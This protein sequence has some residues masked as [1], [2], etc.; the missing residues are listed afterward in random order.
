MNAIIYT[1]LTLLMLHGNII[2]VQAHN[3]TSMKACEEAEG[4]ILSITE[5]AEP[6]DIKSKCFAHNPDDSAK[7]DRP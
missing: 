6:Y 3:Y 5:G 4:R 1:G 2:S 7:W